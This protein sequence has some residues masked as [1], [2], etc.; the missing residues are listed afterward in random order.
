MRVNLVMLP[1]RVL[2][3]ST[4]VAS[5]PARCRRNPGGVPTRVKAARTP[6]TTSREAVWLPDTDAVTLTRA[7]AALPSRDV[8]SSLTRETPG[9]PR[10]ACSARPIAAV[11]AAVSGPDPRLATM[12]AVPEESA[13]WNGMASRLA[14]TLGLDAERKWALLA[15][16]TLDRLGSRRPAA[17]TPTIHTTTISQRNR[18]ATPASAPKIA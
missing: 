6:S 15:W 14:C 16:V 12:I 17:I 18:V 13:L 8:P 3:A 2:A 4:L 5:G 11:S 7:S 10:A 1:E 9:T